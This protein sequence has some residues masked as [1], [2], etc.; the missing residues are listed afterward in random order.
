MLTRTYSAALT[1]IEALLLDVEINASGK[2]E[3]TD[4]LLDEDNLWGREVR[5]ILITFTEKDKK[6]N[7]STKFTERNK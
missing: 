2:Y 4:E 3:I 1:G 6:F 5:R 7:L